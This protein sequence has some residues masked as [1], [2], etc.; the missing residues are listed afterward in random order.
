VTKGVWLVAGT[1]DLTEADLASPVFFKKDPI[2][3]A[4]SI[5]VSDAE[6]GLSH[7]RPATKSEIEGLECAAVWDPQHV[8]DR[9]RDHFA[10]RTNKWVESLR[11]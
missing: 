6:S 10:G 9:L 5:Y 4:L 8:E 1:I 2:N 7:E 3:G 11:R